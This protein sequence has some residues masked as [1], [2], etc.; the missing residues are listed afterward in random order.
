MMNPFNNKKFMD[1]KF[2]SKR[3]K[4]S[5]IDYDITIIE[6]IKDIDKI[7]SFL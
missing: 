3:R 7:N 5:S 4:Y 2:H 6:I 1:L